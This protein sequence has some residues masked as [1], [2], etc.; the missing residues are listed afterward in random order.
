[1]YKKYVELRD[2]KINFREYKEDSELNSSNVSG[3][4]I[5]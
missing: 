2:G 5:F 3:E 1:M 4:D